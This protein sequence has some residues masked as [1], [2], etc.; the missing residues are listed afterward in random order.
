MDLREIG[1][2]CAKLDSFGPVLLEKGWGYVNRA[3]NI[4]VP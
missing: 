1:C 3:M 2:N 4:W